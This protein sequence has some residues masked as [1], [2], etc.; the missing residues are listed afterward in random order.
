MSKPK[1]E[2]AATEIEYERKTLVDK[3]LIADL[4]KAGA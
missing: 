2:L 4:R 3:E 1:N